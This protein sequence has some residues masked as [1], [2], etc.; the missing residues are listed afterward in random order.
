MSRDFRCRVELTTVRGL[1]PWPKNGKRTAIL[2]TGEHSL[3]EGSKGSGRVEARAVQARQIL[4]T[5][6]NRKCQALSEKRWYSS[7]KNQ[8]TRLCL[9]IVSRDFFHAGEIIIHTPFL[10]FI[11]H[12]SRTVSLVFQD[13]QNQMFGHRSYV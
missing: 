11:L 8:A 2:A 4:S 10:C 6:H 12:S 1:C 7:A 13:E 3:Y 5:I 9:G